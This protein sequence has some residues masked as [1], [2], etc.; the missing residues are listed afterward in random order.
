MNPNLISLRAKNVK[1]TLFDTPPNKLDFKYMW[2]AV[3]RVWGFSVLIDGYATRSGMSL[4]TIRPLQNKC[5]M[6]K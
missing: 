2:V 5:L 6:L 3:E 4:V 1:V